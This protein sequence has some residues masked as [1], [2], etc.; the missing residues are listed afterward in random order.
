MSRKEFE[1]TIKTKP[2]LKELFLSPFTVIERDVQGNLVAIPYAKAYEVYLKPASKLLKEAAKKA[3]NQSLKKYLHS[4][5]DAFLSND[6]YQS[7]MDWMDLTDHKIEIVIG[8]Y[9]VY[10]DALFGYKA[11]FETFITL[12][13]EVESKK[14]KEI[15]KHLM[16]L[17]KNLPI[18]DKYK[19]FSRGLS[20]PI[21]VVNEIF[22]AGDTKADVQ[23]LA[24]NLPNDERVREAKGSKKVMLKNILQAKFDKIWLP[25]AEKALIEEDFKSTSF[26][27]YFNHVLMHEVSHGLG[28]GKIIKKGKESSVRMELRDLYSVIEE[29][30]ADVLGI[31]NLQYLIN[32]G[33]MDKKLEPYIYATYL[34]GMFRSVRFGIGEAHGGANAIELNYILEKGGFEFDSKSQRYKVN[35]SKVRDVI[36]QLAH[37]LL[38]IEA[39]GDYTGAEALIRKYKHESVKLKI[40]LD[41]VR[42]V[43]VDI[44]PKFTI[45]K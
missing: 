27:A 1:K 30:K 16:E 43:P 6:Y 15:G 26:D 13:D 14:L 35:H 29:A 4:R 37:E 31:Y 42:N 2:E 44:L 11:A 7:D 34:G 3:D 33:V 28:P 21:K 38:F 5:A 8:P 10:E 17:E 41:E 20:S 22:T 45:N 19:N 25:I 12:V 24:F 23:T 39:T 40:I 32:K 18:A 36:K 9:E